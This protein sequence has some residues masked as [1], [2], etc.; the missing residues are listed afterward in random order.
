MKMRPGVYSHVQNLRVGSSKVAGRE[1]TGEDAAGM[2]PGEDKSDGPNFRKVNSSP[3]Q[4]RPPRV[5][6]P[7]PGNGFDKSDPFEPVEK[8]SQLSPTTGFNDWRVVSIP[9]LIK[10]DSPGVAAVAG[11]RSSSFLKLSARVS[12]AC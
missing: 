6:I 12:C 8:L 1:K 3:N 9:E 7:V 2:N 10:S 11:A 5:P 4:G